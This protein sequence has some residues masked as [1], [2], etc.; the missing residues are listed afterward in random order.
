MNEMNKNNN[1]KEYRKD[2]VINT[3][4]DTG[5]ESVTEWGN[6]FI[7]SNTP[8]ALDWIT[9]RMKILCSTMREKSCNSISLNVRNAIHAGI[10]IGEENKERAIICAMIA[11]GMQEDQIK[12]IIESS[13]SFLV[14]WESIE[15]IA[16]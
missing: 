1:E 11:S 12:Q 8:K 15:S 13:K 10:E 14:T 2:K 7:K 16:K 4:L 9:E 3:L 6:K 5:A